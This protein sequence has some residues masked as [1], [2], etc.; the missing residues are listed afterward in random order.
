MPLS[1]VCHTLFSLFRQV[2]FPCFFQ[3]R[4]AISWAFS[5]SVGCACVLLSNTMARP[6]RLDLST[7]LL[8]LTLH[9][10][11]LKPSTAINYSIDTFLIGGTGLMPQERAIRNH[12]WGPK[13]D[14]HTKAHCG[15]EQGQCCGLW[16][17]V[18]FL[19]QHMLLPSPTE[20]CFWPLSQQR[21]LHGPS[22]LLSTHLCLHNLKIT[23]E[24]G[25]LC[26]ATLSTSV[27]LHD[28]DFACLN[29]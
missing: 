4:D 13:V 10:E 26:Y 16:S 24:Q 19:C 1:S 29:I 15:S 2:A 9:R 23:F 3:R 14:E 12:R 20:P 25:N 28:C 17:V 5:L 6:E 21:A 8:F 7:S 11:R 22:S 27:F 18:L